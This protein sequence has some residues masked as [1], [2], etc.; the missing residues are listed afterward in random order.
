MEPTEST[1]SLSSSKNGLHSMPLVPK[2]QLGDVNQGQYT[3]PE[4]P[5]SQKVTTCRPSFFLGPP[6]LDLGIPGSHDGLRF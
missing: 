3:S 2:I 4:V 5:M 1:L 6:R